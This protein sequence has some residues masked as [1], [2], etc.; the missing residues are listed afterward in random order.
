MFGPG[1][2]YI[3]APLPAYLE[4]RVQSRYFNTQVAAYQLH[5]CTNS[6]RLIQFNQPNPATQYS[7]RRVL[8]LHCA[9]CALQRRQRQARGAR[10]DRGL[11]NVTFSRKSNLR[12]LQS[13]VPII[14]LLSFYT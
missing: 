10:G 13:K 1:A 11:R 12:I 2:K 9:P 14:C 6:V 7:A 5:Y 4:E 3:L 8:G